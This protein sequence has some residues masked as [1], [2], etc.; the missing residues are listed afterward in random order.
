MMMNRIYSL[1]IFTVTALIASGCHDEIFDLGC[2]VR[3]S[4][5]YTTETR[6]LYNFDKVTTQQS[7]DIF[8][9]QDT[10]ESFK[11]VT[12]DNIHEFLKTRIQNGTLIIDSDRSIRPG[13]LEF[14]IGMTDI[15]A[16]TVEGSSDITGMTPIKTDE[17]SFVI[18][19]SGDIDFK[20]LTTKSINVTINGS[21]DVLLAGSGENSNIVISGSGDIVMDDMPVNTS[22]IIINCSGDI[23][24]NV[25]EK[26]NVTISGSGDI[27][28]KGSPKD[29]NTNISG[30]GRLIKVD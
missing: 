9:R 3:G 4:G 29:I 12:D 6:E 21:G 17:L 15:K 1:I 24:V 16:F 14:Y 10:V 28:Y 19:G 5:N 18:S 20:N 30:S 22:N 27:Y 26:L 11:V 13:K 7:G 2:D 8:V 25:K 23:R